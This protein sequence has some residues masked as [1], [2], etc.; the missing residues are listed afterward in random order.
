MEDTCGEVACPAAPADSWS[1]WCGSEGKWF[2]GG[3]AVFAGEILDRQQTARGKDDTYIVSLH[4]FWNDWQKRLSY[5]L[6]R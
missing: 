5:R 3:T 1:S 4:M 6:F 2:M